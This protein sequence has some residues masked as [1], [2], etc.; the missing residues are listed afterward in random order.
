MGFTALC[1]GTVI[2]GAACP[3]SPPAPA[4]PGSLAPPLPPPSPPPPPP[5]I[6]PPAPPLQA[7]S[8]PEWNYAVRLSNNLIKARLNSMS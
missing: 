7:P 2:S 4:A 8:A 5:P 1:G 3:P 6:P